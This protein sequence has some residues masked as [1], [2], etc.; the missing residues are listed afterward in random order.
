MVLQQTLN[1]SIVGSTP[2][3]PEATEIKLAP[4]DLLAIGPNILGIII[5][6]RRNN[7]IDVYWCDTGTTRPTHISVAI[8]RR[9]EF[10]DLQQKLVY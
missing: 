10:L 3:S 5:G 8:E 9:K 7:Y 1:L 2:A 6:N 4:G